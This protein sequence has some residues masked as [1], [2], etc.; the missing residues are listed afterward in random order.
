MKRT[1]LSAALVAALGFGAGTAQAASFSY[2]GSLQ[3]SGKPAQGSYDIELTLYSAASGGGVIGGPLVMYRVPVA[4]GNFSTE[5]DFGPLAQSFNQ[6]YISVRVRN[7]GK[8]EFAA[9]EARAPVSAAAT[10]VCPGAWTTSGNAGTVPGTGFGQNYL[11]TA[12]NTALVIAVNGTQGGA[13][14]PSGDTFNTSTPN[15]V[16]GS[17]SNSAASG[18]GG[19]TIAGGGSETSGGNSVTAD[20][21]TVG[22]GEGNVASGRDS[23]VAGGFLNL[24]SGQGS[25]VAGGQ[26][27]SAT[28]YLSFAAGDHAAANYTGTFVWADN[29]TGAA[30]AST[31]S[32]QFLVQA[33]GGV[34]INSNT[35][36][37]NSLLVQ[38]ANTN[39]TTTFKTT[40]GSNLSHVHYG[41]KGDWYIRS[42]DSTGTVVIQ[43]TGGGTGGGVGIGT[44]IVTAGDLITTSANGAHLTKGGVWTNGS[45]RTFKDLLERVNVGDVLAKVLSMPV[46]TWFYRNNHIEGQHMGPMAEDFSKAFGLGA[47]DK[48]IGTV[49]ESGVAFAAIQGLNQKVEAENA[50]LKQENAALHE[51]LDEVLIRL[52]K[53]ENKQGQ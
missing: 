51:K 37:G 10:S 30:F 14:K 13:I 6:A 26:V 52:G 21:A 2:H 23:T 3:D 12:D 36:T 17:F 34:G 16:F 28:G 44:A 18:I 8:G 40:K 32:N 27:N 15:V 33:A 11:G 1:L 25:T 31:S 45:S 7:A 50:S 9:L 43:D 38:G 39:I 42:A 47:D 4:G 46:Q 35:P 48:H 49:D 53:L 22:G 5:A 24:A 41:A 19:G 29:S 20:F